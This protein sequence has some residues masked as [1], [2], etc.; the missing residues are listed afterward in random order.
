MIQDKFRTPEEAQAY[1]TTVRTIK[2]KHEKPT[3]P[4]NLKAADLNDWYAQQRQ[5]ELAERKNREEAE[6]FIRGYRSKLN[7]VIIP[8]S[9]S[10]GGNDSIHEGS[11]VFEEGAQVSAEVEKLE[12]SI[13]EVNLDGDDME[14]VED[15]GNTDAEIESSGSDNDNDLG[16]TEVEECKE[17][18]V[19]EPIAKEQE[20]EEDKI[21]EESND[22]HVEEEISQGDNAEEPATEQEVGENDEGEESND[23]NE[24]VIP[25]T[26]V[27]DLESATNK[28][29]VEEN[30][31]GE[32]SNDRNED[33]KVE[34]VDSTNPD[35]ESEL[36]ED[37]TTTENDNDEVTIST[38]DPVTE[39]LTDNKE[40]ELDAEEKKEDRTEIETEL[41]PV[42]N[43]E[44]GWRFLISR[45]ELLLPLLT[46]LSCQ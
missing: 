13:D 41:T 32:E 33:A 2:N 37:H 9:P 6:A 24:E 42:T 28:Q 46:I 1:L 43:G 27:E 14:D 45:G 8:T 26:K 39:N 20:V 40:E 11:V 34:N 12:K 30:V 23:G 21:R 7:H 25:E 17:E 35:I 4:A 31:G 29:E 22:N 44:N 10:R 15:D 36:K 5:R 16:A 3:P 19:Q 18:K 38:E